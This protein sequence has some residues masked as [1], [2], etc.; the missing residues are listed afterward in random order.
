MQVTHPWGL[1][2]TFILPQEGWWVKP[3]LIIGIKVLTKI[4]W[5]NWA[6]TRSHQILRDK[7][8]SIGCLTIKISWSLE[9]EA[10]CN[11]QMPFKVIYTVQMDKGNQAHSSLARKR[12][13]LTR[14]LFHKWSDCKTDSSCR[15]LLS[16]AESPKESSLLVLAKELWLQVNWM[17]RDKWATPHHLVAG[18]NPAQCPPLVTRFLERKSLLKWTQKSS[19]SSVLLVFTPVSRVKTDMCLSRILNKS[20]LHLLS[21][22]WERMLQVEK[23]W[24]L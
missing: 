12:M 14:L 2:I 16:L 9:L 13:E 19:W 8:F 23:T 1:P 7:V 18:C 17:D 4:L 24:D 20:Y 3:T 22:C 21:S 6:I 11:R 10:K 5:N 15:L